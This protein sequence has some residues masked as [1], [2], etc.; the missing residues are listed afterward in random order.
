MCRRVGLTALD[1]VNSD[2][3]HTIHLGIERLRLGEVDIVEPLLLAIKHLPAWLL[4][5][6]DCIIAS[7]QRHIFHGS[8]FRCYPRRRFR[9]SARVACCMC[10]MCC[11]VFV[12]ICACCGR[13]TMSGRPALTPALHLVCNSAKFPR[14]RVRVLKALIARGAALENR[15]GRSCTPLHRAAGV[16]ACAQVQVAPQQ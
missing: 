16:G 10:C 2:G 8:S 14:E 5:R 1:G 15:D 11:V 3:H 9:L 13:P 4:D 6:S 7:G 12:S